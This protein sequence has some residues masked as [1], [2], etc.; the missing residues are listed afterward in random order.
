MTQRSITV[1]PRFWVI[2]LVVFLMVFMPLYRILDNRYQALVEKG[3]ELVRVRDEYAQ[4]V[5]DLK[6]ELDYVRSDAGI[7]RYA[8]ALGMIKDGEIKYNVIAQ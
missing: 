6:R 4:R 2:L 8:R 1:K 5:E 7:E 3:A